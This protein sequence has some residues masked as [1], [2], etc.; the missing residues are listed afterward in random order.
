MRKVLGYA[1]NFKNEEDAEKFFHKIPDV[2][3]PQMNKEEKEVVIFNVSKVTKEDFSYV[4]KKDGEKVMVEP[5]KIM[6][7]QTLFEREE[8]LD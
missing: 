8:S 4:F 1:I 3:E 6:F 2:F 7:L 5:F